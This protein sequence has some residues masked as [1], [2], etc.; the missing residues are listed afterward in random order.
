M[1]P[2][3]LISSRTRV[4]LCLVLFL[5]LSSL[6]TAVVPSP[7][8]DETLISNPDSNDHDQTIEDDAPL[9]PPHDA[10]SP[11]AALTQ[12]HSFPDLSA[13]ELADSAS[14][15]S[16]YSKLFPLTFRYVLLIENYLFLFLPSADETSVMILKDKVKTMKLSSPYSAHQNFSKDQSSDDETAT[17][18]SHTSNN[19][20]VIEGAILIEDGNENSTANQAIRRKKTFMTLKNS[21]KKLSIQS[22]DSGRPIKKKGVL[23]RRKSGLHHTLNSTSSMATVSSTG[24]PDGKEELFFAMSGLDGRQT[25]TDIQVLRALRFLRLL[26]SP[27]HCSF[28]HLIML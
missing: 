22:S 20:L 16:Q 10:L 14:P 25:I 4:S 8:L 12:S 1:I 27:S 21:S 23:T 15:S 28:N 5:H 18:V 13:S 3:A 11:S 9:P 6:V 17:N 24:Q 26:T 7:F 19:S 2:L